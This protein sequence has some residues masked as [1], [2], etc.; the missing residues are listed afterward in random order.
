MPT[1]INDITSVN[2][3]LSLAG[4]GEVEQNLA[5]IRQCIGLIIVTTKGTD[6]LR[7]EFGSDIWRQIDKPVTVATPIIVK[8]ILTG[9]Q[10]WE[11]RV[12]VT[13]LIYTIDGERILFELY[14]QLLI[15]GDSAEVLFEIDRLNRRPTDEF[16]GRA[17][18]RGF[19]FAFR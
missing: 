4:V 13:N 10:L 3:Q 19:S 2:W 8:E 7:P 1:T 17:F 9:I 14:L 18:G 5:D 11:P 15:N 12:K 6:P 16:S